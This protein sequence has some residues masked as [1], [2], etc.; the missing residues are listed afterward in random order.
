M[1][2]AKPGSPFWDQF[3]ILFRGVAPGTLGDH[4]WMVSGAFWRDFGVILE[5]FWAMCLQFFEISESH[6]AFLVL[7][8]VFFTFAGVAR[9]A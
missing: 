7:L 2:S 5:A 3:S 8:V 4:F 9:L 1:G 6:L